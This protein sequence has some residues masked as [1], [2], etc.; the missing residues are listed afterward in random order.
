MCT[1][2][3]KT[4]PNTAKSLV[5]IQPATSTSLI[6]LGCLKAATVLRVTCRH[7]IALAMS[8]DRNR[9]CQYQRG[10]NRSRSRV[11]RPPSLPHRRPTG[12]IQYVRC[13]PPNPAD[14]SRRQVLQVTRQAPHGVVVL[15]ALPVHLAAAR[16]PPEVLVRVPHARWHIGALW[17]LRRCQRPVGRVGI[18]SVAAQLWLKPFSYEN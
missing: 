13:F 1:D 2:R 5:L 8:C 3:S 17:Q 12:Y 16:A 6:H 4:Q 10:D 15:R 14:S 18:E 9:S 7:Q 11:R